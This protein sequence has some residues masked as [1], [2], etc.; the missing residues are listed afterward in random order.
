MNVWWVVLLGVLLAASSVASAYSLLKLREARR[1]RNEV[2]RDELIE[3]LLDL[4]WF[5]RIEIQNDQDG[6]KLTLS[7]AR[8][9]LG[10][11][12][13]KQTI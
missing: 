9:L 3:V 7:H 4:E 10:R 12:R 2:S 11:V 1:L 6:L 13:E 5:G 8:E